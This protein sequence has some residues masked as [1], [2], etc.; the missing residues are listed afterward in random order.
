MP[1]RLSLGFPVL[2]SLLGVP[3]P[4]LAAVIVD[5]TSHAFGNVAVS[6][7][8]VTT[9]VTVSCTGPSATI[10]SVSSGAGCAEFTAT[11]DVQLP[12]TLSAGESMSI[13][14]AYDPVD[15]VADLCTISIGIAGAT[16]RTVS[17]SGDG[18]AP[19]L[20][21]TNT[22]L[23]F[24]DQL[25]D[26][27]AHETLSVTIQNVGDMP[28]TSANLGSALTTGTQ[29]SLGAPVGTFPVQPGESVEVPV[30]FDPTSEGAKLDLLTLSLN[31]DAP[32]EPNPTVNLQGAGTA[33]LGVPEGVFGAPAIRAA[34]P[35]P[36]RGFLRVQVASGVAG[37]LEVDVC[38]LTGRVVARSRTSGAAAGVQVVEFRAGQEWSPAPGLYFVRVR[39]GGGLLGM[40]RIVVAR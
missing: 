5:P 36:T 24:A 11:P 34:G 7:G 40:R 21:L 25:W 19:K 23:T 35:S 18:T 20:Q 1:R 33:A 26:S 38:D 8:S 2:L 30:T 9:L 3:A 4:A 32:G 12:W 39:H 13:T 27:P 10:T 17:V 29:F 22:S 14:I 16:A 15:R 37:V 6:A 28:F 31:N